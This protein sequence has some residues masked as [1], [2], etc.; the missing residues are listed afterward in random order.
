MLYYAV[1][2][3]LLA[4]LIVIFMRARSNKYKCSDCGKEYTSK[5]QSCPHCGASLKAKEGFWPPAV[6]RHP[7]LTVVSVGGFFIFVLLLSCFPLNRVP[8]DSDF[9]RLGVGSGIIAV[10]VVV[11]IVFIWAYRA[12]RK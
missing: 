3:L 10:I 11:S 5:P 9:I 12:R 6:K 2:I 8:Y 4:V 7:Y 1:P